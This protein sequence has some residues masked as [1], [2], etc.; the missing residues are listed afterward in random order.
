MSK[1]KVIFAILTVLG[2]TLLNA[3]V[4]IQASNQGDQLLVDSLDQ[5]AVPAAQQKIEPNR[6]C[7]FVSNRCDIEQTGNNCLQLPR[8]CTDL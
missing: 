1:R 6:L 8:D 7:N 5:Q 3:V 2:I 4:L